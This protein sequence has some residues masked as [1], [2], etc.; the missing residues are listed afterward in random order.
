M[1]HPELPKLCGEHQVGL[2]STPNVSGGPARR[3][4]GARLSKPVFESFLLFFVQIFGE[5]PCWNPRWATNYASWRTVPDRCESRVPQLHES[6]D[7]MGIA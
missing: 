4:G 7:R 5:S 1:V 3:N 2:K 6:F